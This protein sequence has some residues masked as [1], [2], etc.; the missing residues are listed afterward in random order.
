MPLYRY[1]PPAIASWDHHCSSFAQ[2]FWCQALDH[3]AQQ[4]LLLAK[5]SRDLGNFSALWLKFDFQLAESKNCILS[6]SRN[7]IC[8]EMQHPL[9]DCICAT[10]ILDG[11]CHFDAT[12]WTSSR[13]RAWRGSW[14]SASVAWKENRYSALGTLTRTPGVQEY[15]DSSHHWTI[16][17]KVSPIVTFRMF[18]SRNLACNFVQWLELWPVSL[19]H[20]YNLYIYTC[21]YIYI[22]VHIH[23]R[24]CMIYDTYILYYVYTYM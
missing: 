21:I 16:K 4:E 12:S 17:S 18:S 23:V 8:S 22:H 15:L 14:E 7:L 9:G 11:S 2:D 5:G 3:V 1:T 19:S 10:C 6:R 20:L 13:S 24:V